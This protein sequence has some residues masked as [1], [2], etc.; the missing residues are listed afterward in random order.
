MIREV[1]RAVLD[2]AST[3]GGLFSCEQVSTVL[4]NWPTSWTRTALWRL[5]RCGEVEQLLPG[6]F[7]HFVIPPCAL[8]DARAAWIATDPARRNRDRW[9]SGTTQLPTIGGRTAA[10]YWGFPPMPL[11][12]VLWAPARSNR[13]E[14]NT[15]VIL[16]AAI[17]A[18]DVHRSQDGFA[19]TSV[20]RT[21]AD[22]LRLSGDL[23]A[24]EDA[25]ADCMW[26]RYALRRSHLEQLVGQ[27]ATEG[28]LAPDSYAM[29]IARVGGYPHQDGRAYEYRRWFR[30]H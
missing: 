16:E 10:D 11:D 14:L 21:L 25:L 24:F 2:L 1:R 29:V 8:D 30:A 5:E 28:G 4:R 27:A 23:D 9:R 17:D 15:V 18:I 7:R 3:Q 20:E 26:D 13:P 6:V 12:P 19:Y 22:I